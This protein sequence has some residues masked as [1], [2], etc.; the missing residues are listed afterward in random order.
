V[1]AYGFIQ[2]EKASFPIAMMCEVLGVSRSG[3][4]DWRDRE[5]SARV[6]RDRRLRAHIRAAHRASRGTYGSPRIRAELRGQG[7][8]VSRKRV[9]RLMQEDAL[10]GRP[11]RKW[12]RTT[13]SSHQLPVA[14]NLLDRD[15]VTDAPNRV[16]AADLTYINTAEGWLYLAVVIDLYARKVVGWAAAGHMRTE[17]CLEALDKAIVLRSPEPGLVHHSD[18]GSQYASKAYRQ[19]LRDIEAECSMSRK[20]DCWDNAV[21]ESFFGT[22]KQELARDTLWPTR[23]AAKAAIND[24]I[25]K[26]YN[27]VRRHSANGHNSPNVHEKHHQ[28]AA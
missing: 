20:G 16:W 5:P 11:K 6:R 25:L 13:D 19:R 27:P 28:Q 8:R 21:V 14:P 18:R 10:A 23:R 26:F 17:L 24:Y 3:F 7:L 22:L 9:A 1:T 4:Y 12:K 15:F 2:A